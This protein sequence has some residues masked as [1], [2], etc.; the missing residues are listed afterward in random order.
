[1]ALEMLWSQLEGHRLIVCEVIDHLNLNQ[2]YCA[3]AFQNIYQFKII[4]RR[5]IAENIKS[6]ETIV[7]PVA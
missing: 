3:Y 5:I 7:Q 4:V 1:M 6:L 2:D